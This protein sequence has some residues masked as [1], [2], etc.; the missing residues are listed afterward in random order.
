MRSDDRVLFFEK[1]K[2]LE[3]RLDDIDNRLDTLF[4][5]YCSSKSS[6]FEHKK[7]ERTLDSIVKHIEE[8]TALEPG[9]ELTDSSDSDSF[10]PYYVS[11]DEPTSL[12]KKICKVKNDIIT[13]AGNTNKLSFSFFPNN[14]PSH[15]IPLVVH[16][17]A[18]PIKI[19]P[20]EKGKD[21]F[22]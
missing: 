22:K 11:S 15:S 17:G 13:N 1:F 21:S 10:E 16:S 7:L 19:F 18:T 20:T 5:Y 9:K 6:S 8:Q 14:S 2:A 3:E 4:Y 12:E